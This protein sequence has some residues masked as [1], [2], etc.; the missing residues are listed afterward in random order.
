MGTFGLLDPKEERNCSRNQTGG[1]GGGGVEGVGG[2]GGGGR[3]LITIH[4]KE[5]RQKH[6]V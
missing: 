6:C 3:G 4:Q 2:G 1:G 5:T